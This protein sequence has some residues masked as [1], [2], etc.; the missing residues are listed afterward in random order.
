MIDMATVRTGFSINP[1]DDI[2]PV[3][4]KPSTSTT[5]MPI[6]TTTSREIEKPTK[7]TETPIVR[8]TTIVTER[9]IS[10]KEIAGNTNSVHVSL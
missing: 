3:T 7:S 8:L 1:K 2:D 5:M 4:L 10:E 9:Y 6:S